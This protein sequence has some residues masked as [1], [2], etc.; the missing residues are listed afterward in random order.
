MAEFTPLGAIDLFHLRTHQEMLGQGLR[1]NGC[2]LVA[3]LSGRVAVGRLRQRL[4]QAHAA[5]PELRWRLARDHRL[6]YVWRP[7]SRCQLPLTVEASAADQA[8]A[9][10]VELVDEPV[11]GHAPWRVIL[12]RGPQ[13]DALLLHWF[14]PYAD[15][16]GAQRFV[17]WLGAAGAPAAAPVN[18][19]WM[20]P[21]RLLKKFDRNGKIK[22]AREYTQHVMALGKRP[23]ISPFTARGTGALGKQAVIRVHFDERQTAAFDGSLRA[24]AKLADTSLIV[25][26]AARLVDRVMRARGYS[27]AQQLIPLPLSL[28]P[29]RGARRMFGNHLTMMMLS[30]DRAALGDE[31][32]AVASLAQQRRHIVRHK[33]DVAM[34]A[35]LRLAWPLPSSM[36]SWLMRRP[37]GGERASL[38]VSNPGRVDLPQLFGVPVRDAYTLP[39]S[40]ASPGVQLIASRYGGR[41]S[42]LLVFLDGV[43]SRA[44]LEA[45]L[46]ILRGD[47][48]PR[49]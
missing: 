36:F 16:L 28:D 5:L 44:E 47:L 45:Q 12:L 11:A 24:R 22:L 35:G 13:H 17:R 9:R 29:K 41:L 42:L 25:W 31:G 20:T 27:P 40:L 26:A 8:L 43:V 33:Y 23:I 2:V 10:A 46:P 7:Q 21:D 3:Q 14:H 6:H 34:L 1:G 4:S 15:A 30:L 49:V 48:L 39:A 19:R 18:Q 38:V 32:V 37:F